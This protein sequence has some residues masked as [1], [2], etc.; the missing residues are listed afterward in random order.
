MSASSGKTDGAFPGVWREC[1]QVHKRAPSVPAQSVNQQR[2]E[3]QLMEA[4][5]KMIHAAIAAAIVLAG[6]F[7]YALAGLATVGDKWI[8][9]FNGS[10]TPIEGLYITRTDDPTWGYDWVGENIP[11]GGSAE[12]PLD[13]GCLFDVQLVFADEVTVEA[14]SMDLCE[15][16][17]SLVTDGYDIK[18][19]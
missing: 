8:S 4:Q 2:P 13:S 5:M 1:A 19:I 7:A 18:P 6:T 9:V 3:G 14:Y 16:G 17:I 15:I 10:E 12:A 11:A